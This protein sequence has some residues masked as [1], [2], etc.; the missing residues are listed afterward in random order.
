MKRLKS[1]ELFTGAGGLALGLEKTGWHHEALI[2]RNEHAC[3]TIHMNKSLGH[4][5][6]KE[7]RLF[8]QDVQEIKYSDVAS[9]VDMVAGG[10]PCQPFSLGGKHRAHQDQRDMFPEAVRAV[11]ELRPMCFLFENVKGLVRQS[12]ASYFQYVVLQLSYPLSPRKADERWQSHLSRLER[13]H[14]GGREAELS[15]RVVYRLLD[16]ADYG[17]PQHRHR[18]FIVGFRSDLGREWS[19][20]EPTHSLCRLL[21]EQWVTGSYW[22]EHK[23]PKKARPTMP[24]RLRPRLERM[25]VDFASF[26]PPG[27]RCRTVRDALAGLPDPRDKK[28]AFPNHEFRDGARSYT[29]HTGSDMDEPSKALKAG[30]HGVPGGENMIALADGSCRYYTVRESARVQTFPDDYVFSGSWTEA[31][32]QIG[33]AV[34]VSLAV[35]VGASVMKQV[36]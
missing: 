35:A 8:P 25:A 31:M 17:V 15:Y 20:P 11:R 7:W 21:W 2:E 13:L 19:F 4:P 18:V 28:H 16:A 6:A 14:T 27:E 9:D 26:P 36:A 22:E 12:F 32:R 34:P 5:L 3:S 30:D 1:V 29:G 10:P 33:N 24:V 23:L